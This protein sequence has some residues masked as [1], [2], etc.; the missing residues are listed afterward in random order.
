M[1]QIL[2]LIRSSMNVIKGNDNNNYWEEVYE[3]HN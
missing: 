3:Y 1:L 2:S